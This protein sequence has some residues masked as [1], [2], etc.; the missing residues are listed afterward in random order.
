[1]QIGV[2]SPQD[3]G[4]AVADATSGASIPDLGISPSELERRI[5]ANT[6]EWLP[7]Q[8]NEEEGAFHG[9][10]SAPRQHLDVPQT[11]NL[12]APW[13]LLAAYDRYQDKGLLTMARQAAEWFYNH[14]VVTHPMSVVIGGVRDGLRSEE[15]WTKFAAEFVILN[16]GLYHRTGEQEYLS[17]A[18]QSA[19]FLIQSA[20]HGFSPKYNQQTG[21]WQDWGWQSFGRVIEAFLELER[22]TGEVVWWEHAVRW[23]EFGLTLQAADG[24]FYLID[25]EYFNT[26]LAAD[27][28]RA[29]VFLHEQTERQAFL[30]SAQRFAEWLLTWQR[31]D[32]A[33]PLTVDRDGNV[34]VSTVGPGDVPNIGVALLRLHL[35]TGEERYQKAATRAF[36][37]SLGIQA[38]PGSAHPYLDDPRVCWGF[39]SWDPY[40]DY[41]LSADQSTHHVRGMMFLLDTEPL[42]RRKD[43]KAQRKR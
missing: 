12:I 11:V 4:L 25:D 20:R 23:G 26:D 1:M 3:W 37:Y 34:V 14:F 24:S 28:L 27:E 43:A 41:T 15:L 35:V 31:E 7:R 6:Y 9:F 19:G 32:G 16:V 13:Q 40:Y 10:Y 5:R 39:W 29:M 22:G 21:K 18:R 36:H 30:Q 33:W 38:I 42:L 17:R 8:F 2:I